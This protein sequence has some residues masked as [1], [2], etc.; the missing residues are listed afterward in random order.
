MTSTWDN[1]NSVFFLSL[2]TT[3]L[4]F[5]GV[6]FG[7]CYKSKCKECSICF[8]IVRVQRDV[9]IE[10]KEDTAEHKDNKI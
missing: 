3:I 2:A 7:Y 5:C 8:G 6:A 4:T 10:F 1:F 9:E